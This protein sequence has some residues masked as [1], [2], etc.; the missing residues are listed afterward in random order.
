MIKGTGV[1]IIDVPRIKKMIEK[2]NRFLET[3]FTPEEIEYSRSKHSAEIHFAARF[4]A[5]EAFFKALGTGWRYGM[6][7]EEINIQND[8]LGKPEIQLSGKTLEF[9][10][11]LKCH[12]IHLSIS[13]TKEYA[14]AF[15]VLE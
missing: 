10:N 3:V 11:R 13:H 4:A 8:P 12:R 5:K 14:V 9:F 15:V 6:R 1:D 7:W 2:G